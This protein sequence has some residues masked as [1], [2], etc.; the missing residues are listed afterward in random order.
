[1]WPPGVVGSIAHRDRIAWC[2][3]ARTSDLAAI[4]IDA[5]PIIP[6]ARARR[7]RWR[8]ATRDELGRPGWPTALDPAARLTVAFSAKEAFYKCLYPQVRRVFDFLDVTLVDVNASAGSIVL[9]L[10]IDLSAAWTT[11]TTLTGRFKM[12]GTAVATAFVVP[13]VASKSG[14]VA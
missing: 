4:G 2:A 1:M 10:Q 8:I 9:Q 13:C 12:D 11:G 14:P 3:A 7:V 6:A 5:E